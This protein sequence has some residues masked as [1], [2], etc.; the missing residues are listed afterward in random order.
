M[1][2]SIL[3]KE[4]LNDM[5][6]AGCNFGV[7]DKRK[8]IL[9]EDSGFRK[10]AIERYMKLKCTKMCFETKLYIQTSKIR[11]SDKLYLAFCIMCGTMVSNDI[12]IQN[13]NVLMAFNNYEYFRN[14]KK[15]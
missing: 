10:Q 5:L 9:H 4:V 14:E 7:Y 11:L 2:N 8:E 1:E 3:Y 13:L 15:D 12:F 6:V